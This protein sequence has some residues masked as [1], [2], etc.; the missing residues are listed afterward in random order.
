MVSEVEG[1]KFI[2]LY[3]STWEVV[4]IICARSRV[5]TL[6]TVKTTQVR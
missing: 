4:Y 2:G 5:G 3:N 1:V 6:N